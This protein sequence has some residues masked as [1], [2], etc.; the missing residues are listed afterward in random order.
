MNVRVL[1]I[2][3]LAA[4]G[5]QGLDL[6]VQFHNPYLDD[7]RGIRSVLL[8]MWDRVRE[9][10]RNTLIEFTMASGQQVKYRCC[11]DRYQA[12][13]KYYKMKLMSSR[14]YFVALF[15]QRFRPLAET[16][17]DEILYFL[18]LFH[19]FMSKEYKMKDSMKASQAHAKYFIEGQQFIELLG[20]AADELALYAQFHKDIYKDKITLLMNLDAIIIK[21]DKDL[22]ELLKRRQGKSK[23]EA[24]KEIKEEETEQ[25]YDSL[26]DELM[27]M[28]ADLEN[29]ITE[30]LEGDDQDQSDDND[31]DSQAGEDDGESGD[32]FED[33]LSEIPTNTKN[34]KPG[35]VGSSTEEN[36][37][38]GTSSG[39]KKV[40]PMDDEFPF[41]TFRKFSPPELEDE[42]EE[43]RS[44]I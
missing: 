36:V 19:L 5:L 30:E 7:I 12:V 40:I 42:P 15:A 8:E 17:R 1:L 18:N 6:E 44:K 32:L 33:S 13:E 31:S 26:A 9:C 27:A 10:V 21:R 38:Q 35:E 29:Q 41:T 28:D 4:A 43:R 23:E 37:V 16:H 2:L 22:E 25:E 3:Q 34:V 14:K 39:G 24:Q 20:V 11:G